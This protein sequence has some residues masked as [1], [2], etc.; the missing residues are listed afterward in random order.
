MSA[1][2]PGKSLS[3]CTVPGD[4][5]HIFY[6]GNGGYDYLTQLPG[7]EREL[8]F[9]GGFLRNGQLSLSEIGE[10]NDGGIDLGVASHISGALP[11]Y[12]GL[13]NWGPE[14]EPTEVTYPW[15]CGRVKALWTGV[16]A[17]SVD[18]RPW[19]GRIPDKISKQKGPPS[20]LA[21]K[22]REKVALTASPGEYIAAAFTGEGM[23]NAWQSGRALA[24]IVLGVE[25][26]E[27]LEEWFPAVMRVSERRWKNASIE[28]MLDRF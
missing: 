7:G 1:Q 6:S 22:C 27:K 20:S 18:G 12:F 14:A 5:A 16:I 9:G 13:D 26:E 17:F 25:K 15:Q 2:R 3:D 23:V 28:K 8:M 11:L 24:Y 21:P 19:V 4:R 10:V